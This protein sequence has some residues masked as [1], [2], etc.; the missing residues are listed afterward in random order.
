MAIDRS[1]WCKYEIEIA[2]HYGKPILSINPREYNG[3]TPLFIKLADNQNSPHGF[4][5]PSIIRKICRQLNHPLPI[6]L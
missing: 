5:T 4:D 2:K 6:S 1:D 3:N